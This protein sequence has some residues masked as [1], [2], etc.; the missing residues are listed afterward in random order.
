M[1]EL[2]QIDLVGLSRDDDLDLV[3]NAAG[4]A[5]EG[6]L[7][8]AGGDDIVRRDLQELLTTPIYTRLYEPFWG[9]AFDLHANAPDGPN[10][11]AELRRE[12]RR[13][14][15]R[16]ARVKAETSRVVYHD[17]GDEYE[18]TVKSALTGELISVALRRG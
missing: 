15:E 8:L 4:A 2:R 16:D 7:A 17:D 18:F 5:D 14:M 10:V 3:V 9:H 11:P 12:W 13:L 6:Q 1:T